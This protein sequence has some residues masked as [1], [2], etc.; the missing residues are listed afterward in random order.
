LSN[1]ILNNSNFNEAIV[2]DVNF[3]RAIMVNSEYQDALVTESDFTSADLQG[4]KFNNALLNSV[5]LSE[6][7]LE[8]ADFLNTELIT[9]YL[10]EAS[11]GP[12]KN[13]GTIRWSK[14]YEIGEEKDGNLKV[15]ISIYNDLYV[16]YKSQNLP[17][18][19]EK[20]KYREK[21]IAADQSPFPFKLVRKIFSGGSF[22]FSF[23]S[24]FVVK[25]AFSVILLFAILYFLLSSLRNI[26]P[27]I[28]TTIEVFDSNKIKKKIVPLET[29][30]FRLVLDSIIF[31][32]VSF[33]SLGYSTLYNK[34]R[35]SLYG[36]VSLNYRAKSYAGILSGV[37]ALFGI[38]CIILLIVSVIR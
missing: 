20:F 18:V 4:V 21:A 23:S 14:D 15:A 1:I 35:L 33:L 24:A 37:E 10:F 3:N 5:I 13:L 34:R 36:L 6:A 31:S 22:G 2:T 30:G 28:Y 12:V 11:L 16:L 26:K 9:P 29:R 25:S 17:R 7:N 32:V 19:A 8:S 27:G 38:I